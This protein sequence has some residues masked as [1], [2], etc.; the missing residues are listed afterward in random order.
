MRPVGTAFRRWLVPVFVVLGP[1]SLAFGAGPI[2][3]DTPMPAPEWALLE[4]ALIQANSEACPLFFERYFDPSG[5]ALCVE[6]WGGD[7]GPDDASESFGDW[8]MLH[9]L[10]APNTVLDLY[11]KAWEG[12]LRQYTAAKTVEVPLARDGM[13]YREFPTMFDWLHHAEGLRPFFLQGLCEPGDDLLRLR[14][15]RFAGFYNGSDPSAP[16][17]DPKYKIIKSLIN[18][19]RGPLLRKATALD[20]AGDPIDVEGR[21]DLR[22]GER[23]YEQMLAH[24]R[25]Y[26]DVVGDHPQNL[27][28]TSL[29]L[30]AFLLTGRTEHRDWVIEY[31]N[32][33]R[34]RMRANH[35]IIPSNIG[36]DGTIGGAAGGKWHGGTYGWAFS[37]EVPQ[38]GETAH[39]N[40]HHLGLVGFGNALLLTGDQGYVDAW[41][42]MIEAVNSH[43]K[44]VDG[45]DLYPSMH[46]DDGWYAF[47]PA[48]YRQGALEVYYWSMDPKDRERL[49]KSGWLAFLEGGEP[50]YPVA[51]LRRDLNAVRR[52]VQA[53]R[54]DPTTPD[55]RLSDDILI[56]DPVAI[57][58]LVELM[59]GGLPPGNGRPIPHARVRYFDPENRRAGLPPDVGALVERLT[60]DRVELTLVNLSQ[61]HARNVVFQGGAF[62]EHRL[63]TIAVDGG[64]ASPTGPRSV[65]VVLSP[66][67][68][69]RFSLTM[70]RYA[71]TPTLGFPWDAPAP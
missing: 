25:D 49:P 11:R 13:Y 41:R 5:K 21:F 26:N 63:R 32:A 37:V 66:G 55:T 44:S 9:A 15:L 3:V 18:G 6:R 43:K 69:A 40:N 35:D 51:V 48:P 65:S 33:W 52:Q 8:P 56:R 24:F 22:H 68:G 19:S 47:G 36:L 17:Y 1:A 7:D 67:S 4:R 20:W 2:R 71:Q 64:K 57:D 34:D 29:A 27:L 61:I 58:S 50:G 62:G 45:K 59:M 12:H 39:R 10:G 31:V 60:A 23:S 28:A 53:V 14:T 46:G 42:R 30:N 38:T 16:N 54:D 70:D